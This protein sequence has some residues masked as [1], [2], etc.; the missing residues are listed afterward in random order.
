MIP[1][2]KQLRLTIVSVKIPFLRRVLALFR[3]ELIL[4]VMG[5]VQDVAVLSRSEAGE[6]YA[7]GHHSTWLPYQQSPATDVAPP[8]LEIKP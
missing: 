5:T 1:A 3:G 4:G 8:P 7:G 6:L 2:T